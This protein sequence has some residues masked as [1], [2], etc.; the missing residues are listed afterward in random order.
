MMEDSSS[1]V[2]IRAALWLL[3]ESA[4]YRWKSPSLQEGLHG[5]H[6]E[7]EMARRKV[8]STKQVIKAEGTLSRWGTGQLPQSGTS[9]RWFWFGYYWV[10]LG[11]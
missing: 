7:I 3:G 1:S 4:S 10:S 5:D 9:P 11:W 2:L 6:A 8:A